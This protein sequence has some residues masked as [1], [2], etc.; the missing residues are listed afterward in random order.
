[1]D[2]ETTN[3]ARSYAGLAPL[4]AML[5]VC[6]AVLLP[7][8]T[9]QAGAAAPAQVPAGA[10]DILTEQGYWR[11]R[12]TRRPP[13]ISP[14]AFKAAG[15]N[16]SAA[17]TLTKLVTNNIRAR[18]ASALQ[19]PPLPADWTAADLDDSSWPRSKP[20]WL[21]LR[22]TECRTSD[23]R[24]SLRG[25]FTVT[26]PASS[27]DLFFTARY[28]GGVAVF[29]NGKEVARN[30]L[31][32][33]VL[34]P[35][36]SAV[37]YA[38]DAWVDAKG[39]YI[40][41]DKQSTPEQKKAAQVRARTLGP[42]KL[43][44]ALLRKGVNV[45]A[46]ELRRTD[47]HPVARGWKTGVNSTHGLWLPFHL[48]ELRLQATGSGA[49][50]NLG[51]PKGLRA[52]AMD[53]NDR[54]TDMD[55]PDPNERAQPLRVL[56]GRN[57]SYGGLIAVG[58]D[59]TI[60]G[61][62]VSPSDL[63]SGTSTIPASSVT[64]MYG[65]LDQRARGFDAAWFDGLSDQPPAEVPAKD[66]PTGRFGKGPKVKAGAVQLVFARFRIPADAAPGVYRGEI[67][68]VAAG[69]A[70]AKLPVE[71]EVFAWP[72]PD[73]KDFRTYVD[74]YQ[75]PTS[76]SMKY[77]V[78]MWSDEH[79]NLMETSWKLLGRAGNRL[80]ITHLVAETQYGNEESTF[81]FIP[82]ADGSYK[83][84]F[85]DFE[86]YVKMAL[87]HCKRIDHVAVSVWHCGGWSGRKADSR[88]AITV[89]DPKTGKRSAVPLPTIGTPEAE[90]IL[91]PALAA[92][93]AKLKEMGLEKQMCIGH[94][95]DSTAPA[96]VLK[97]FDR[98][99]PGEGKAKWMRGCHIASRAR[100]VYDLKHGGRVVLHEYCY[101][102]GVDK[103]VLHEARK[104][105]GVF[106]FRAGY[107]SGEHRMPLS[108]YRTFGEAA[109][110]KGT[111]GIGR[112]CL[113][114]WRVYERGKKPGKGDAYNDVYNRYPHSSIAQ[115]RPTIS[116]MG[117][118]GPEGAMPTLRFESMI[119]GVQD[120]EAMIY[121][122][123]AVAKHGGRLGPELTKKCQQLLADRR[124]YLLLAWIEYAK[125]VTVHPH[126]HGWQELSRRT[127][128][129]A[130]E[131][132]KKLGH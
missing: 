68:I 37:P 121:M 109:M 44:R 89:Q 63:K 92:V 6:A 103:P 48:T 104:Y 70:P 55:Y 56:G 123:E 21:F 10:R 1:M 110:A 100:D 22:S 20:A 12:I 116:R 78:P 18:G 111:K 33:G 5:L 27:G 87:E 13:V 54:L 39:K 80:V 51:R 75:S 74:M 35:D 34:A 115:R 73:P 120:L 23:Q 129:L 86:R 47:F 26:S 7:V 113:D 83:Y 32:E 72:V 118:P 130:A 11:Y 79:Y 65:R 102:G 122:S 84:D 30:H 38:N 58:S 128:R 82:Q 52:W 64:V 91:K 98:I 112:V 105:P 77:K 97:S 9:A 95:C 19:S 40:R 16:G 4:K 29:L 60:R 76:A 93:Y 61:L 66:I 126:H 53:R 81:R 3:P 41:G 24:I 107:V 119:E 114:M 125:P 90:K 15:K 17:V 28:R 8:R 42:V 57:G 71:L 69:G 14:A 101:G 67:A 49:A 46:V 108:L 31:P 132:A 131:V 62:K 36:T 106:Y 85:T 43:P 25:K 45:L 88:H 94:V 99:W 59:G 117:W 124:Q 96:D 127:Y 50:A 2:S